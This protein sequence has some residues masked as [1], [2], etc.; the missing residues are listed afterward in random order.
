MRLQVTLLR[1]RIAERRAK[2]RAEAPTVKT[3]EQTRAEE[4]AAA[5]KAAL[6]KEKQP[7]L[8]E[9]QKSVW[10]RRFRPLPE[11][12]AV[13]LFADVIGDTFIL[14]VASG[15]IIYEYQRAAAKPDHNAENIKSIKAKLEE[16]EDR[17]YQLEEQEKKYLSRVETLEQAIEEMKNATANAKNSGKKLK[18]L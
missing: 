4:K 11:G 16:L 5:E 12:K 3:E 9:A 8:P 2:E 14:L 15:L 1:D 13:D 18:I 10:K 17:E 6:G 7:Q